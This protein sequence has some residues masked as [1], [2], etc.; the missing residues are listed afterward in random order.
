MKAAQTAHILLLMISA[1]LS[2]CQIPQTD[3]GSVTPVRSPVSTPSVSTSES[4]GLDP[5][6]DSILS[7]GVSG[8]EPE[9]EAEPL[10]QRSNTIAPGELQTLPLNPVIDLI[11]GTSSPQREEEAYQTIGLLGL[12]GMVRG[13]RGLGHSG[14]HRGFHQVADFTDDL[15]QPDEE[16]QRSKRP[17]FAFGLEWKY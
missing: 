10:L 1:V 12:T 16:A 7:R 13:L 3:P 17:P 4:V 2:G 6:S 11:K 8:E 9:A 5:R 15:L 14:S